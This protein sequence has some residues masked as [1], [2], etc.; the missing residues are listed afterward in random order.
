[1]T[2]QIEAT[3]NPIYYYKYMSEN[4]KNPR[5]YT[6]AHEDLNKKN[7][8][9]FKNGFIEIIVHK[10]KEGEYDGFYPEYVRLYFDVDKIKTV[11]QYNNM[12]EELNGLS[13]VFGE[14]TIGGYTTDIELASVSKLKFVKKVITVGYEDTKKQPEVKTFSAHVVFYQTK[15]A[16]T[17]ISKIFGKDPKYVMPR[18]VDDVTVYNSLNGTQ[19]FR[20]SFS[21]KYE[22][23]SKY[24]D[25]RGSQ[26]YSHMLNMTEEELDE[27]DFIPRASDLCVTCRGD[28]ILLTEDDWK[29][30]FLLKPDKKSDK[31]STETKAKAKSFKIVALDE[32]GEQDF[33]EHRDLIKPDRD[34][35]LRLFNE[36]EPTHTQFEKVIVN[37]L[38]SPFDKDYIVEVIKD[39]YFAAEHCNGNTIDAYSNYYEYTESNKWFFSI[40]KHLPETKRKKYIEELCANN[41]VDYS[42]EFE[43][44]SDFNFAQLNLKDYKCNGA[45]GGVHVGEFLTDLK[46]ILVY[47]PGAES[48]VIKSCNEIGETCIQHIGFKDFKQMLNNNKVGYYYKVSK[49]GDVKK[50]DITAFDIYNAGKNK[51]IFIKHGIR[52]FTEDA[53]YL[54]RFR[55][56]NYKV[57]EKCDMNVVNPWLNH[58]KEIICNN[59]E[60]CYDYVINWCA[61]NFQEHVKKVETA[62][63]ITGSPGTGK[64][65][66]ADRL[67]HLMGRYANPNVNKVEHLV[68]DFNTCHDGMRLVVCNELANANMNKHLN[69]ESLKSLIT[70]P[71]AVINEKNEK[72]RVSESVCNL[73][74]ISNNAAPIKIE[75]KDRRY[76]VLK[77][78][79]AH[80]QDFEYFENLCG[81]D[82]CNFNDNFY[83][84][85]LTY[86]MNLDISDFN[87]RKIPMTEAKQDI[88][89]ASKSSY[90]L[91]V[92]ARIQSFITQYPC[93]EAYE[94]YVSYCK[95]NGLIAAANKTFGAEVKQ[96]C[97]RKQRTVN[98]RS[99]VWCY[100]MRDSAKK[101]F[102]TTLENEVIRM[103]QLGNGTIEVL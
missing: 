61:Y 92:Q 6:I 22:F 93:A 90:E 43:L 39:W 13:E 33:S 17:D 4:G 48:Y 89:D 15:I 30:A 95:N 45:L 75:D 101:S 83:N 88:I 1:M 87:K 27:Y 28:E 35:L 97:D 62:L 63:V 12:I 72:K 7:Q 102:H 67:S 25:T 74:F 85:L 46:R 5:S 20:H 11:E 59:D 84:N 99:G 70:E 73:I 56:Y 44:D 8:N 52:F 58:V 9:F 100:I 68:G 54:S 41:V 98:G 26:T 96:F 91:F 94:E 42:I 69:S 60:I 86:F 57:L 31:K 79:E 18:F 53:N 14:Y 21:P 80:I 51:N 64:N 76:V 47:I 23:I 71:T 36:F 38:K 37:A 19:L 66:F 2:A 24:V 78:S 81:F 10:A 82:D 29:C 65:V 3:A 49:S 34:V 103:K 16:V 32:T 55:G 77:T 50:N 40:L